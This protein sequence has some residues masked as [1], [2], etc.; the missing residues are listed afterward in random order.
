VI[1]SHFNDSSGSPWHYDN[2][3]GATGMKVG[4]YKSVGFTWSKF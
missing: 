2:A 4:G 3:L 1:A